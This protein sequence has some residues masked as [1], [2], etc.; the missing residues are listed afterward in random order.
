M[1]YSKGEWEVTDS[2]FNRFT[3][4]RNKRTGGRIFVTFGEDLE[5]IAEVQGDS[6]E[7]AE[8]N[9]HL[10]AAAPELYEA[11]KEIAEMKILPVSYIEVAKNI[12][13][14]AEVK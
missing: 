9:A 4:Y 10:I 8:A 13:A 6:Q 11:M 7:E 5:L 14:K 12:V 1:N 3:T 2:G